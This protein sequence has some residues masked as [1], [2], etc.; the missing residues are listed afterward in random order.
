MTDD[1]AIWGKWP[2]RDRL[3]LREMLDTLPLQESQ[4]ATPA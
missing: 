2:E 3:A 4:S 1:C